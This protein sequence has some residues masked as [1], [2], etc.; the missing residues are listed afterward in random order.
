M[1]L[2]VA[3]WLGSF[4]WA[5]WQCAFEGCGHLHPYSW[6]FRGTLFGNLI[7]P[8]LKAGAVEGG[9]IPASPWDTRRSV[10]AMNAWNYW[11]WMTHPIIIVVVVVII[12]TPSSSSASTSSSLSFIELHC[13][14][15]V[16]VCLSRWTPTRLAYTACSRS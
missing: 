9:G 5:S 11:V 16:V 8:A 12:V 4:T 7:F 3:C 15:L 6:N 14:G 10:E 1:S 2:Q 13:E